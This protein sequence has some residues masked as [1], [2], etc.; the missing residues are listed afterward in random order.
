MRLLPSDV[1]AQRLREE[2][3]KASFSRD[4]LSRRFSQLLVGPLDPT[5]VQR[6]EEGARAPH[7]AS[8]KLPPQQMPLVPHPWS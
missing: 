5:L 4:D 3:R 6:F 7:R 8:T 1:F 2:R